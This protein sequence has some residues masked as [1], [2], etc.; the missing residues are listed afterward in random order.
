MQRGDES[1][2]MQWIV[3]L[4]L[5]RGEAVLKPKKLLRP[6]DVR[7]GDPV[8]GFKGRFIGPDHKFWLEFDRPTGSEHAKWRGS[9][10]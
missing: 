3:E 2:R 6:A 7:G 1:V 4:D 10:T 5:N 9:G 8:I